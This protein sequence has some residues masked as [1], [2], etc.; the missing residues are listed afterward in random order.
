MCFAIEQPIA[1]PGLI[2]VAVLAILL[3]LTSNE[4]PLFREP[5]MEMPTTAT[6]TRT[7]NEYWFHAKRY[8]W[9][10]GLPARWQG[11][12]V[13]LTFVALLSA[14]SFVFPPDVQFENYLAAVTVLCAALIAVC[15]RKGEPPR[16]RWGNREY[17]KK[18]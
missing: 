13:L 16:W 5:K 4:E 14:V 7:T 10:W 6:T 1:A 12:L 18:S 11:W 3:A 2:A 17:G 8:G 15:W 9:G